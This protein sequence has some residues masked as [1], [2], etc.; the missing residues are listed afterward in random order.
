MHNLTLIDDDTRPLQPEP[1]SYY[2]YNATRTLPGDKNIRDYRAALGRHYL[3]A[4]LEYQVRKNIERLQRNT[5]VGAHVSTDGYDSLTE[6]EK[7][8]MLK[9]LEKKS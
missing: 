1:P 5:I 6:E 2:Q 9:L 4:Q 7:A 3:A 8:E